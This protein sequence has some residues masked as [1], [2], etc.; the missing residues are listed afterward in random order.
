MSENQN[1]NQVVETLPID[2]KKQLLKKD[3][4]KANIVSKFVNG[5]EDVIKF[6]INLRRIGEGIEEALKEER[7]KTAIIEEGQK[8]IAGEKNVKIYDVKL[9]YQSVHTSYDFKICNHPVLN[10]WYEI[11]EQAKAEIK[12]IEDELKLKAAAAEKAYSSGKIGMG[13]QKTSFDVIVET[14]PKIEFQ[15]N[16]EVAT[17]Q[18]PQQYKK[19]GIKFTGL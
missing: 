10:A 15:A 6:A 16:G 14:V 19:M 7:V 18:L 11:L 1:P 5:S 8:A 4:I 17:V 13:L 9:N 12:A 3:E 2:S